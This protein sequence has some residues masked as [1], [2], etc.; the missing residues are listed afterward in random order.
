LQ[1]GTSHPAET[2]EQADPQRSMLSSSPKPA[3][4]CTSG[5]R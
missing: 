1:P 4:A 3:I 2:G 5:L